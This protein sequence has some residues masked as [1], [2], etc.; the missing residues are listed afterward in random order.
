[1]CSNGKSDGQNVW[2]TPFPPSSQ[3]WILVR[4]TNKWDVLLAVSGY[5]SLCCALNKYRVW[6]WDPCNQRNNKCST[7]VILLI[8]NASAFVWLIKQLYVSI[9]ENEYSKEEQTYHFHDEWEIEYLFV[10][11]K[12]KCCCLICN[13]SVSLPKKGNLERHYNAVHSNKYDADFP[14]KSEIHIL[15]LKEL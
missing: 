6:G 13:A 3:L 11:V 14:P 15:K 10:M 4:W 7:H 5:L 2:F 9:V 12:D 8:S 1:M